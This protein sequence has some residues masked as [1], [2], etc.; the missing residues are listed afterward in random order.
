[1]I[2]KGIIIGIAAGGTIA[3]IVI[4]LIAYSSAQIQAT[5]EDV[6]FGGIDT[7]SNFMQTSKNAL[8]NAIFG[9]WVGAVTS[10]FPGFKLNLTFAL[11]NHG[12]FQVEIPDASYTLSING[13]NIGQGQSTN[14]IDVTIDPGQTRKS[15]VTQDI[16][17]NN[18]EPAA[19]STIFTGGVVNIQESGT[20]DFKFLGLTVPVP[21]Y[22]TKQIPLSHDI[23]QYITQHFG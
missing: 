16:Q 11:T 4:G 7:P 19:I 20:A 22:Y 8:Q 10:I 17:F 15:T 14:R 21:F 3:A 23:K 12:I 6:S 1:M 2:N 9:N 18:L 5:L 13:V